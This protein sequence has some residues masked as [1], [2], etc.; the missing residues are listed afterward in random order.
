M[1]KYAN[2]KNKLNDDIKQI[3][4]IVYGKCSSPGM[5]QKLNSDDGFKVVKENAD[6]V[7]LMKIIERI[8]YNYQPHKYPPLGAWK[9]LDKLS[10]TRQHNSMTESDQY[11][12]CKTVIDV[13]N[14]SGISFPLLFTHTIDMAMKSL[15]NEYATTIKGTYK[16]NTRGS[17]F[18]LG[19][20]DQELV[21]KQTENIYISTHVLSLAPNKKFSVSKQELKND[22]IKRID[23]Y[24]QS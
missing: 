15:K 19:Q 17:C 5:Q 8:Y 1:K 7:R 16:G 6:L 2:K 11:K 10:K 14:A 24:P 20:D 13:C 4:N 22:L 12:Q 21:N 18:D 9:T 3:F 23:N